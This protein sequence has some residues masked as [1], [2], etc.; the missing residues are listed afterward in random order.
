MNRFMTSRLVL[1]SLML[2][3]A[4]VLADPVSRPDAK[5]LVAELGGDA[6]LYE[7]VAHL[8][9]W[10][11]DEGDVGA[12]LHDET[13]EFLIDPLQRQLDAGDNS[14]FIQVNIPDFNIAATLKQS[15][16]TLQEL[17]ISVT[18][19]GYKVIDV[20]RHHGSDNSAASAYVI[21]M[22]AMRD[23]LFRHR[24][25]KTYPDAAL[26]DHL[27]A[28]VNEKIRDIISSVQN[29]QQLLFVAP[30]SVVA[31]EVWVY[32]ENGRRLIRFASDAD[33]GNASLWQHDTVMANIYDVD[34][35]VVVSLSEVPGSNAYLTR[36]QVGRALYNCLVLGQK[37]QFYLDQ[38][39][40][41]A[42]S[43]Q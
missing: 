4:S 11:L 24:N 28:E 25:R 39:N 21:S 32:W 5:A 30:I 42:T 38:S 20:S 13:L 29:E 31:N 27:S 23:Y 7:L 2:F 40:Q 17:D 14:R 9:R 1:M 6:Y 36:D 15:D 26:S 34:E 19:D 3:G 8:Y 10:Y 16:Y 37:R 12:N 22:K 41:S 35:Q 43:E 18:S 33:L